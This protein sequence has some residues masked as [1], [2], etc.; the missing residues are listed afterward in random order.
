MHTLFTI[1]ASRGLSPNIFFGLTG[2][3]KQDICCCFC[4]CSKNRNSSLFAKNAEGLKPPQSVYRICNLCSTFLKKSGGFLPKKI[5]RLPH[6]RSLGRLRKCGGE[7]KS[8]KI[9]AAVGFEP[10]ISAWQSTALPTTLS[11]TLWTMSSKERIYIKTRNIFFKLDKKSSNK[12]C[13]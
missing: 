8:N 13:R 6:L 9:M 12:I 2:K 5:F 11:H 4:T 10:G 1:F 7:K 3:R